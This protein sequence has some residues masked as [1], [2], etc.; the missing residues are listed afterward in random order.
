MILHISFVP[1]EDRFITRFKA[2]EREVLAQADK[3]GKCFATRALRT[4]TRP[5]LEH[6]EVDELE[7]HVEEDAFEDPDSGEQAAEE[8]EQVAVP[9]PSREAA[10]DQEG[11]AHGKSL[12][13][14]RNVGADQNRWWQSEQSHRRD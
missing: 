5:G 10:E 6:D 8:Q 9:L 12:D 1:D 14:I 2:I 11:D 7:G 13:V 3:A 4:L